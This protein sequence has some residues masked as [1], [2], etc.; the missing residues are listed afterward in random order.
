MAID[1]SGKLL[2]AV[3]AYTGGLKE[4]DKTASAVRE[5]DRFVKHFR[6]ETSMLSIT[7]S[8]IGTYAEEACK[9]GSSTEAL[10]GLHAVRKFLSFAYKEDRT[11][12]NLATHFRIRKP[13]TTK[14]IRFCMII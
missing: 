14:C 6:G 8:Q 12:I 2:T 1:E 4:K 5:L 9:N 11:N 3:G 7:P 10:E 13:K